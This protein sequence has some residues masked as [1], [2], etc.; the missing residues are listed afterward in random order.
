MRNIVKVRLYPTPQQELS[1]AKAFGTV[2]WIWNY[3]LDANNQHYRATG[4]G[5]SALTLKKWL[6]KLKKE[7][8][9][10]K[11]T[12]S[13]VLQSSVLGLGRAF[14]NFFEKRAEFPRFKSKYGKQSL[15]YPQNVK[16]LS[17]A[18]VFPKLGTI[19]AKIHRQFPG[20]LKT[21]TISKTKTGKYYASLLFDD[22][23]E[24]PQT[25]TDGKAIGIDLGL[26]D[27]AITSDGSK[28]PNPKHLQK[29]ARNLKRKQQSLSRKKKGSNRR[30]KARK[31][32]AG[33]HEKIAN[34]RQDFLH[35]LSHKLVSENQVIIVENL[36]VKGMVRNHNL[37]KA[38]SDCGWGMFVN[39][40]DYKCKKE[41]KTLVEIDRWFPSSKTCNSCLNVVESLPLDIREWDCPKCGVHHD[42][43]LNAAL[44]IRDEGLR[45]ISCGTRETANGGRV[46]PRRGRKSSVV[47]SP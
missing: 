7:Y 16:L 6:P 24:P 31:L 35:K 15:Q 2:R 13:Q 43:D 46:R 11:E 38:I 19:K 23:T 12:Y 45:I 17:G 36:N 26:K 34:T 3:C 18:L 29:Y 8:T 41:G 25:K 42:R 37:A 5:I 22:G 1:L 4:K 40:L 47:A 44:N 9:W 33:V 14:I 21:V 39:F 27:F 20:Y 28:Y 30:N 10:L 32:V